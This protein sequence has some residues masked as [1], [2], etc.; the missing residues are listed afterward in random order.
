[1]RDWDVEEGGDPLP[2]R[3]KWSAFQERG[4]SRIVSGSTSSMYGTRRMFMDETTREE[5]RSGRSAHSCVSGHNDKMTGNV[6]SSCEE[7]PF[8]IKQFFSQSRVVMRYRGVLRAVLV[9]A[10]CS[11]KHA[12]LRSIQDASSSS[13]PASS[14]SLPPRAHI[15]HGLKLHGEGDG[16]TQKNFRMNKSLFLYCRKSLNFFAI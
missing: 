5:A 16:G 6:Q 12:Q 3:E 9:W 14:P 10:W 15:I 13:A 1:M 2:A 8:W 7:D 4:P 11:I